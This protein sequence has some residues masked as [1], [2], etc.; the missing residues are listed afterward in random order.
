[1]EMFCPECMAPLVSSDGRTAVCPTHGGTYAI[2]FAR[3]PLAAP[4]VSGPAA[5]GGV[6]MASV[7]PLP[8]ASSL[9]GVQCANH[10]EVSAIAVCLSCRAP[11]C[12]TCDFI[13][14][15][16]VHLCPRCAANPRPQLSPGRKKL[17]P[18]SIGLAVLSVVGLAGMVTLTRVVPNVDAQAIGV[19]GE[20]VSLLPAIIGLGLGVASFE[21]RLKT[22]GIVWI[23]VIGNATVLAIWV[24]LII[25]G[26]SK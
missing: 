7:L 2:L 9:A 16:G 14:P 1:M 24:L 13:F 4:A 8:G 25:V 21:R 6:A 11:V 19:V 18:W 10:P 26:L 3:H 22:P 23:G 5:G 17:I 20:L 15:G 12:Q